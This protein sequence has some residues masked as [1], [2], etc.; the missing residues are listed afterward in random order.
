MRL[1]TL[2]VLS[3]VLLAGCTAPQDASSGEGLN[4]GDILGGGGSDAVTDDGLALS[5]QQV[6]R[7]AVETEP[8]TLQLELENV[9]QGTARDIRAQL[10]GAFSSGAA[11]IGTLQ[12]IDRAA[13]QP[14]GSTLHEWEQEA[15]D[16]S[17]GETETM[18]A[19]VKVAYGYGTT[20]TIPVTL[21]S[22]S[23][24]Q[25]RSTVSAA[26]TAGPVAI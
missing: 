23:F 16:V 5:F 6:E 26:N 25:G 21:V 9:G 1:V 19:G 2:C 18:E 13:G 3:A 4:P 11:D 10:F 20:A 14:G 8:V 12:G 24:V 22:E 7:F 15:P 17:E